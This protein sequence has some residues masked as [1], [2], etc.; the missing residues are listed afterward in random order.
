[1]DVDGGDL[2]LGHSDAELVE[3]SDDVADGVAVLD[4]GALVMIDDDTAVLQ[5]LDA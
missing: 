4:R 1:M 3:A 2:T 5:K